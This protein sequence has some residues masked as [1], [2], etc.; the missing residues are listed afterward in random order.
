MHI[1]YFAA[2]RLNAVVKRDASKKHREAPH[3]HRSG[4]EASCKSHSFVYPYIL[5]VAFSRL[6]ARIN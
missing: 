1:F 4:G 5:A 6:V 3:C 2:A